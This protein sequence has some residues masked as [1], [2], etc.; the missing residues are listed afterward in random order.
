VAPV[1]R[2]LITG[3]LLLGIFLAALDVLV[4]APAIPAVVTA[5][6]YGRLADAQ[7]RKKLYLTGVC[8]LY[9]PVLCDQPKRLVDQPD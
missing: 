2:R 9:L 7:G 8:P 3:A 5:P 1:N 6:I 4:V